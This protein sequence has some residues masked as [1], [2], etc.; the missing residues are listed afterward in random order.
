MTQD[1]IDAINN[2]YRT[3]PA[4]GPYKR[5]QGQLN[6]LAAL[7]PRTAYKVACTK[8]EQIIDLTGKEHIRGQQ[9]D[10]GVIGHNHAP[11][12]TTEAVEFVAKRDET[13]TH[14][15]NSRMLKKAW[16]VDGK[17]GIAKVVNYIDH[18]NKIINSEYSMKTT[19]KVA[20]AIIRNK[21]KPIFD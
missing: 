3:L 10:I 12:I 16:N 11:V 2:I 1:K 6:K 4:S 19:M 5:V 15:N 17:L 8:H 21:I 9:F 7:L 13:L 18:N 14:N 20:D